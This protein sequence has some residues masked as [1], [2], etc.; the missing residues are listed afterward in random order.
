MERRVVAPRTT[1]KETPNPLL[2]HGIG[3]GGTGQAIL[4]D[5]GVVRS[6]VVEWRAPTLRLQTLTPAKVSEN[7]LNLPL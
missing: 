4:R 6:G 3:D 7:H 1:P 5:Y 2:F